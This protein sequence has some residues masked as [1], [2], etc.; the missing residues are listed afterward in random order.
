MHVEDL[1]I[2]HMIGLE[3]LNKNKNLTVNLS[4]S[5]GCSVLEV[6]KI[7]ESVIN[8]KINY[9]IA[10]RRLG[11]PPILISKS[12]KAYDEIGWKPNKSDIKNIISSMWK[13][14]NKKPL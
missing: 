10:E 7:A 8:K 5:S 1:A 4:T 12:N 13:I 11:D 2:A 9:R 6:I 3:Y 14:Y